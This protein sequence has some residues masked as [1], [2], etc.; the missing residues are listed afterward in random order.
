MSAVCV[1]VYYEHTE[2][3][4]Q[5]KVD[6]AIKNWTEL[7]W[8]ELNWTELNW[9]M[10]VARSK[11][12]MDESLKIMGSSSDSS[13]PQNMFDWWEYLNYKEVEQ[14]LKETKIHTLMSVIPRRG[15]AMSDG[16][17]T[18]FNAGISQEFQRQCLCCVCNIG[19]Y[20]ILIEI[21]K[22]FFVFM[23]YT[24]EHIKSFFCQ[25]KCSVIRTV[26]RVVSLQFFVSSVLALWVWLLITSHLKE[27]FQVDDTF[28]QIFYKFTI[29]IICLT[30][31][32]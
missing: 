18:F 17:H 28:F 25:W 9:M 2:A 14:S 22:G 29:T 23:H 5:C 15:W 21:L 16:C 32:L 30:G 4:Y 8:I 10:L 1:F 6:M 13:K 20:C 24:L 31:I 12:V 27:I 7:S 26:N 11:I 3:S 19:K